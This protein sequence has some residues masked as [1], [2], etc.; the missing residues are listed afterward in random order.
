MFSCG[1]KLIDCLEG[2]ILFNEKNVS[3]DSFHSATGTREED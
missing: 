1:V 2:Q 3:F